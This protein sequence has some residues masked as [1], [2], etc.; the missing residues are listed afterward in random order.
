MRYVFFLILLFPFIL[1]AQVAI[2]GKILGNA[3]GDPVAGASVY[4]NNSTIG[5]SSGADGDYRLINILPGTYEIIISHIGFEPL[6]HRV[7]V[8]KEHLR[9]T[10]RLESKVKQMR[11]ILIMTKDQRKAKMKIFKEQFLGITLAADRS[12][13]INEEDVLFE[14]DEK[15]SAFMAFSEVPLEIINKE[16]GYRIYFELKEFYLD[17]QSG[18]TYFFGFTR[19][20]DLEKGNLNK[21]R[22][23]RQKYYQGS[24]MHFYHSLSNGKAEE[25]GF[26]FYRIGS[27][28]T[29]GKGTMART[30]VRTTPGTLVFADSGLQKKYLSWKGDIIVQYNK[31]P[32]YKY[33]LAKKVMLTGSMKNG[34]QTTITMLEPPAYL[35]ANGVLENPTF[36]SIWRILGI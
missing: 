18:R 24:T 23:N 4:I 33:F 21:W 35:D 2:T 31:D 19:Y 25:Q 5:T 28:D 36:C 1:T 7:E 13:L 9:F 10:F 22:K 16:L 14:A 6:V 20:E 8:G 30:M 34:I 17:Q 11:N 12:Q 27:L 26:S 29:D 3:T 15:P 32:Y